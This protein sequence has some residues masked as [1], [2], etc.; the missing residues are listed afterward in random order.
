MVEAVGCFTVEPT[1]CVQVMYSGIAIVIELFEKWD[2]ENQEAY[3]AAL[4]EVD[5]PEHTS[6]QCAGENCR[7]L[8]IENPLG[9]NDTITLKGPVNYFF[10]IPPGT[11]QFSLQEGTYTFDL[12]VCNNSRV[13]KGSLDP[14][15]IWH[16]GL[17]TSCDG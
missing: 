14:S 10:E 17:P 6:E 1:E 4:E 12:T 8:T 3:E 5:Q 9:L 13:S 16:I 7:I 11:T 2:D 15:Y